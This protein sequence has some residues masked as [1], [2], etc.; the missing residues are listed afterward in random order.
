MQQ[1]KSILEMLG[2][3]RR[4]LWREHL[5]KSTGR[6]EARRA[7]ICASQLDWWQKWWCGAEIKSKNEGTYRAGGYAILPGLLVCSTLSWAESAFAVLAHASLS[8]CHLCSAFPCTGAASSPFGW[9]SVYP[10]FCRHRCAFNRS[11]PVFS[12][13]RLESSQYSFQEKRW[14]ELTQLAS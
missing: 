12:Y 8:P 5:W 13:P 1:A 2:I 4:T 6:G 11:R 10:E 14:I 3:T 9:I 7:Q